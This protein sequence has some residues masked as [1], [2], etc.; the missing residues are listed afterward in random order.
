MA[1]SIVLVNPQDGLSPYETGYK[2]VPDD[3]VP[4]AN[5]VLIDVTEFDVNQHGVW[6]EGIQTL[7]ERTSDELLKEEFQVAKT[8]K[9]VELFINALKDVIAVVPEAEGTYDQVPKELLDKAEIAHFLAVAENRMGSSAKLDQMIQI[10]GKLRVKRQTVGNMIP[11]INT[12]EDIEE[13]QW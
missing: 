8:N 3:Y 9:L 2:A 4:E 11:D 5:E 10:L 7:R 6:D 12:V 13:E 1:N